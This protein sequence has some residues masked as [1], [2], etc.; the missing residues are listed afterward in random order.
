MKVKSVASRINIETCVEQAG[1]D[2]FNLVLIA[3][4]RVRELRVMRKESDEVT[5]LSEVLMEIQE[6]K[7]NPAEY[8]LK[9]R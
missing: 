1:H 3:A 2:K 8:L 6:G 5:Y 7:I 9:V 4:A